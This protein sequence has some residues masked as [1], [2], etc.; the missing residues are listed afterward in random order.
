[1][2][3]VEVRNLAEAVVARWAG[4]ARS[5]AGRPSLRWGVGPARVVGD[6][7]QLTRALDNLVANA[8]EHG[9]G[10]I[11]VSAVV[12]RGRLRILV[13]DGGASGRVADRGGMVRRRRRDPR[14]GHGLA[15]VRSV[16]AAHGGRFV[17]RRSPAMT[18]AVLELPLARPPRPVH[19]AA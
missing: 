4:A 7:T 15:I 18:L 13:R 16:A 17:L 9:R 19:A 6:R 11:D 14:E 10:P 12:R 8:I 5:A 1:L 3:P 2:E